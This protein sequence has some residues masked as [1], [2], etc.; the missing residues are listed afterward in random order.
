[1]DIDEIE[2]VQ[3]RVAW[4]ILDIGQYDVAQSLLE[5]VLEQLRQK[6][7]E[8]CKLMSGCLVALVTLFYRHGNCPVFV[9][10]V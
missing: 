7:G 8:E 4:F 1:M 5:E 10:T 2:P 6:Y 9:Y 3:V